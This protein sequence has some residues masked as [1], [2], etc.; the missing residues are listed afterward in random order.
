MVGN[1]RPFTFGTPISVAM[2][3]WPL[4]LMALGTMK[5]C[6]SSEQNSGSYS[7]VF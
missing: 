1:L 3:I 4:A 5:V 6:P 7:Q 2:L